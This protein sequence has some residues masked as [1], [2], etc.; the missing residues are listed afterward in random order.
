MHKIK[1][2]GLPPGTLIHTGVQKVEKA[3]ITLIDFTPENFHELKIADAEELRQYTNSESVTWVNVDG[4][5]EVDIIEKIGNIFGIHSLVLEDILHTEHRPKADFYDDYAFIVI[6]MLNYNTSRDTF[7]SEQLSIILGR[8]FVITFQEEPGDVFDT[9]RERIRKA[10]KIRQRRADFLVY[11]MMDLVIDTYFHSLERMGEWIE[12]LELEIIR[13]PNRR[14]TL[15]I[16]ELKRDLNFL[17]KNIWPVREVVH[18]MQRQE[19]D[20]MIAKEID[21]YL[22]DLYDHSIQV[23]DTV[24]TYR[25]MIG[26]LMDLYLSNISYK[27]NEVMK[28]LTVITSIFIPLTF[29][30]GIY[31]MNF[32]NMPELETQYG[33]FVILA[34]I[35][36]IAFAMIIYFRRKSWF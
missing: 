32:K 22:N 5:H 27:M 8:N 6:K 7:D 12:N 1:K 34:V 23:I 11:S 28:T 15:E 4:L 35:I 2:I 30:T 3:S 21:M 13:K 17:R 25:E 19:D 16:N 18:A 24:E 29:I 10:S 20:T 33:Y 14:R 36:T 9:I 26:N 31:G